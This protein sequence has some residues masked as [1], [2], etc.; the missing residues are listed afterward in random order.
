MPKITV[1][2]TDYEFTLLVAGEVDQLGELV[3]E[4][5]RP[6]IDGH[7]YRQLGLRAEPFDLTAL[8]DIEDDSSTDPIQARMATYKSLQGSLCDLE[9]GFGETYSNLMILGVRLLSAQALVGSVG[10][11]SNDPAYLLSVGFTLQATDVAE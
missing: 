2:A 3:E 9:D 4:I 6:G 7:A 8:V 1:D 10:H 5:T 11:I